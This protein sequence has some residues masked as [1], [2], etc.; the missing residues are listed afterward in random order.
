[1][2]T[3]SDG[4]DDPVVLS[5]VYAERL[6][7]GTWT[8]GDKRTWAI[9]TPRTKLLEKY[10]IGTSV[11]FGHYV[12]RFPHRDPYQITAVDI[13]A[14]DRLMGANISARHD[15]RTTALAVGKSRALV[16]VLEQIDPAASIESDEHDEKICE[17]ISILSGEHGIEVAIATKLLCIKRPY[18]V[19]MMDSVVQGCFNYAEP[20][21]ILREFR[22]LLTGATLAAIKDMANSINDLTGFSPSPVRILDELIWFDWNLI[23]ASGGLWSVRGFPEWIYDP[24]NDERGVHKR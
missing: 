7:H 3:Q 20:K 4:E 17:A 8:K 23:P 6:E 18:L 10:T 13:E 11:L 2:G 9:Q 12:F 19:P 16:D 24:R 5:D 1:M 21:V 22:R 14:A 15:R